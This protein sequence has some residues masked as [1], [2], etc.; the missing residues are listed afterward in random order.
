[1]YLGMELGMYLGIESVMDLGMESVIDLSMESVDWILLL[2]WRLV[3]L[4]L[5]PPRLL[6]EPVILLDE[7]IGEVDAQNSISCARDNGNGINMSEEK[8]SCLIG[9]APLT[10]SHVT[11]AAFN[12]M[13][14]S[15]KE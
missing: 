10:Y 8:G 15:G 3:L 13:M 6:E 14:D 9:T 1:M 2:G 5:L 11:A 12:S 4:L 7:L